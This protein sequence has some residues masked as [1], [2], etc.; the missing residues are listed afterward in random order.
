MENSNRLEQLIKEYNQTK[1]A[2]KILE[3]SQSAIDKIIEK[4]KERIKE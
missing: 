1:Q 4:A 3:Q 2:I